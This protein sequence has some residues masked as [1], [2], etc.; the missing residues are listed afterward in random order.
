MDLPAPS[1]T[2][3]APAPAAGRRPRRRWRFLIY[4]CVGYVAWCAT[5][6]F[7]QD[8]LIFP[9]DMA[10]AAPKVA[11]PGAELLSIPI[12]PGG[13][14]EAIYWPATAAGSADLT[15]PPK[16]VVIFCH[17]NAEI[18]DFQDDIARSYARLGFAVM[19]PEYRGYGRSAGRPSEAAI[20]ADTVHLHDLLLARPEIDRSRIVI[21]G[22]S[23]G[24]GVAAQ[25]AARR[26]PA[27]LI[28]EST[29]T[30]VA[31][32]AA[33]YGVPAF[34]AT[35]PFHTDRVIGGF[36][37][38]ILLFHGSRDS[39]I[40]VRHGRRLHALAPAAKYVEYDADHNGFPGAANEAA[41]WREIELFLRTAGVLQ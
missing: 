7:Y 8:H 6:Y 31:S 38:P 28:L 13:Q 20:V 21:H 37:F 33:G 23:I 22:R 34:L 36:R 41:Y 14:V 32:F 29:F 15:P 17:G 9:A 2:S 26:P 4:L 40:P 5:L 19:V 12:E 30:S 1:Q 35:S 25:L 11:P 16:P 10:P 24:G 39:I 18:A 3:P 27:A